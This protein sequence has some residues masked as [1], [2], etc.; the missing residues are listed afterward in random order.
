MQGKGHITRSLR[1]ARGF[2]H[3]AVSE[4]FDVSGWPLVEA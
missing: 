4:D 3:V 1:D 2:V